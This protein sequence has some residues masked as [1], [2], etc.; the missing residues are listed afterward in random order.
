MCGAFHQCRPSYSLTSF[1][2]IW[3]R[4]CQCP[5]S[6]RGMSPLAWHLQVL[7]RVQGFSFRV[8]VAFLWQIHCIDLDTRPITQNLCCHLQR[9]KVLTVN[10][11]RKAWTA[12][13]QKIRNLRQYLELLVGQKHVVFLTLLVTFPSRSS[14]YRLPPAY[15]VRATRTW[16]R[17]AL[18]ILIWQTLAESGFWSREGTHTRKFPNVQSW[19][20]RLKNYQMLALWWLIDCGKFFRKGQRQDPKALS[21]LRPPRRCDNQKHISWNEEQNS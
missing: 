7:D 9:R 19:G 3:I 15:Y 8:K 6:V 21:S 20:L 2:R 10:K 1:H 13:E 14:W 17:Q 5:V 16:T 12:P 11:P 18:D 4:L